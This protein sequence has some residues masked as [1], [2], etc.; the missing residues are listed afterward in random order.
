MLA[1]SLALGLID[2]DELPLGLTLPLG[3]NEALGDSLGD[4]LTDT[5]ELGD[6]LALGDSESDAELETL[7][8]G[9]TLALGD[10]DEDGETLGLTLELGLTDALTLALGAGNSAPGASPI[11]N[12]TITV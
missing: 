5:L 4:A 7:D 3:D 12:V 9:E 8:D 6:A 2:D 10:C 11:G 1:L